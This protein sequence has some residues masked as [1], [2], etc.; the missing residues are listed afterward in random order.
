MLLTAKPALYVANMSESQLANAEQLT[1]ALAQKAHGPIVALNAKLESELIDITDKERRELLSSVGITEPA[2]GKLAKTAYETLR[3]ISYLTAGEKEVRAWTIE[4]GTAAPQ[5][6][7]VIHSDFETHFI[8]ADIVSYSDFVQL[9]GW[10][11]SRR[12]GKVRSEGKEYA[13]HEGDIVEFKI[14]T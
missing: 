14:G 9:G 6:A 7:G 3:L 10:L 12:A 2:L 5:A 1:A 8:K 11:E 13:M 4:K